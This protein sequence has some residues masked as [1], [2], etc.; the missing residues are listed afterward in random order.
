MA[1]VEKFQQGVHV[2]PELHKNS[3]GEEFNMQ[4][5]YFGLAF[6]YAVNED[7]SFALVG[8]ANPDGWKFQ[9]RSDLAP[10]ILK[11][12]NTTTS[13]TEASFTNL[14]IIQP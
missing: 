3:K 9:E 5:V 7:G 1:D 12:L 13:E 4:V 14:P 6:A 11:L 2:F 8:C 10:Q